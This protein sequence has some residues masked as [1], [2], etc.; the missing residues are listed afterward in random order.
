MKTVLQIE[1]MS[2]AHCVQHVKDAL[3]A[4][5]G[6]NSAEVSL[7]DKSAAVD[8]GDGVDLAALKAAVEEAGYE[9]V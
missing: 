7:K 3:G 6:V 1:G 9:V 2:C 8:H 4:I 5:A